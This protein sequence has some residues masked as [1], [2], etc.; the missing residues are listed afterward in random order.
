MTNGAD[1]KQRALI[2]GASAG[3]GE[4]FAR[5][6]AKRGYDLVLV[7]RRKE[8]L[9][10]LAS[11]LTSVSSEVIEADL[12]EQEGLAAIE[13]RLRAGDIGLLVNNAGFGTFGE[14]AKLPIEREMEELDLNVRALMRL[15][16]AALGTM[17]ERRRG[18][19]INVA[20]MAAYQP[21]PYNATYSATKVFVMHFS[22]AL[23]EEAKQYGVTVSCVCPGPV[24]TEFQQVAGL[25]EG[26]VPAMAWTSVDTV[27]DTA[28]SA[29]R[30]HHAVATPGAFNMFAGF[31]TRMTPH[32]IT[33]RIAGAMFRDRG[34]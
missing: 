24:H 16:H 4:G 6:L 13:E 23:H 14:F 29:F 18:G 12:C 25:D 30:N 32:F 33:R 15:S 26:R 22:E 8:R 7:A 11:E 5:H 20:S 3:I 19:I 9:D 21:I 31:G 27:V 1:T 28:L 10:A 2:T 17:I 34:A